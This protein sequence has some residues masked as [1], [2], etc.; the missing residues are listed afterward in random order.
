MIARRERKACSFIFEMSRPSMWIL[1]CRASRNRKIASVSED[2][3]AP[4]R[5]TTPMRSLRFTLNVNPFKTAGK[6]G[7][8]PTTRSCTSRRPSL[9][10]AA[11]GSAPSRDSVGR[12]EYSIMRSAAFMSSSRFV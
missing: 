5:P 12:L 8:Y 7:A 1:P 10:H 6:S 9:G 2:L 4:V 11:G 3:P